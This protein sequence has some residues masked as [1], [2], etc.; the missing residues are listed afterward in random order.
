MRSWKNVN[1]TSPGS[2]V[3]DEWRE[4]IQSMR[5]IPVRQVAYQYRRI[6]V[7]LYAVLA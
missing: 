3:R 6:V 7:F 2:A 4:G 5:R 1:P